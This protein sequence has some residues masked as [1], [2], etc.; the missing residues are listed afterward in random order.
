MLKRS[1]NKIAGKFVDKDEHLNAD[2]MRSE[3]SSYG[4][5]KNCLKCLNQIMLFVIYN[6]IY[7]GGSRIFRR[8]GS[9]DAT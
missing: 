9:Q 1:C 8:G 7:R 6:M 3:E 4:F 2:E 5:Q